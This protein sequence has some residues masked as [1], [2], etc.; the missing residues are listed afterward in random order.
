MWLTHTYLLVHSD[1]DADEERQQSLQNTSTTNSAAAIN[2]DE[3]DDDAGCQEDSH[4][5]D[6]Q[7][8]SS[9]L[10]ST[11]ELTPEPNQ[12]RLT[13]ASLCNPINE[14]VDIRKF[15]ASSLFDV[16]I[17]PV[18]KPAWIKNSSCE[19]SFLSSLFT[20]TNPHIAELEVFLNGLTDDSIDRA[21]ACF[22][23]GI[24]SRKAL[25]PHFDSRRAQITCHSILRTTERGSTALGTVCKIPRFWITL[26]GLVHS[27]N[28]NA[29]ET[30]MTRVFC[31][32]GALKIHFWLLDIIPVAIRRISN[33]NHKPKL[34]I[35][36]LATD[37]QLSIHK[38]GS[39]TFK[40]SQYLPD[41]AF[42]REYKMEP[43][44]FRFHDPNLLT[45]IISST[46]RC[47]LC[48]PEDQDSLAQ[49]TLLDIV[50][51]KSPTSILFLDKIWEMYKSSFST[52]FNKDWDVRRSKNKLTQALADFEK[53]FSLHPFATSG[54]LS[55][56]KLQYLSG[57]IN[58]WMGL[59]GLDSNIA[60]SV[61]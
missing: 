59:T 19:Q 34:W 18:H 20:F 35:D 12:R 33:P 4:M 1:S 57:L 2:N 56:R 26:K 27:S 52:V 16:N 46:L 39:A 42:H 28:L 32:Q 40:S 44:P 53:V 31:M 30:T 9:E 14:P 6:A 7:P 47:W 21:I 48:F 43:K 13:I 61:S 11:T 60:E 3:P 24:H 45:S 54:S 29:I 38:G 49:L 17:D 8:P 37:V 5:S 23:D 50:T 36:K 10:P 55:Y 15:E 22:E 41:L 25:I 58:K 51:S